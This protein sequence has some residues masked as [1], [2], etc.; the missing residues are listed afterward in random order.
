MTCNLES[1]PVFWGHNL[2]FRLETWHSVTAVV[3]TA[4]PDP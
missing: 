1:Q 4:D 3:T 2:P